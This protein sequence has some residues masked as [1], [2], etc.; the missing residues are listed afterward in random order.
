MLNVYERRLVLSY[1][2]NLASRLHHNRSEARALAECVA[3]RADHLTVADCDAR[4]IEE[5]L[6]ACSH[7]KLTAA[8]WQ[9]LR[10][11]LK[12]Q[13][14]ETKRVRADRTALRIRRLGRE[15]KLSRTDI[16][17]LD[18][19]L[20]Y[21]TQPAIESIVDAIV[22]GGDRRFVNVL[23]VGRR[24]LSDLLGLTYGSCFARFAIHA[25]LVRSGLLSIDNDGDIKPIDR[26]K[27]LVHTPGNTG[28]DAR[29]LLF[30]IG[31]PAEL[32][33]SDF[34]HVAQG[35]DHVESLLKGALQA[36]QA[37]GTGVNVLIY[38][39]PGTGKTEFC[40][41]LARR[42]KVKLYSV[43]EADDW[44]NEPN[45]CE[46]LQELRLAQRLLASGRD[47]ILLFDEMED[48][49]RDPAFMGM[50]QFGRF[51]RR[52]LPAEGSKVFM[53][54]LLEQNAVP[55]LWTSN[56]A[57]ETCPTVL[58]RMMFALE[59]RQPS[60]QVR[61]RIWARHL[62]SHG[63]E[64]SA[65]EAESL[66]RDYDVT[67]GVAAGVTAA[68]RLVEGGDIATVRCGVR[69]L[70]RLLSGETPPQG[71]PSKFDPALIRTDLDPAVL[72]ERLAALGARRVSLCLNGP[73]GTGKSAY[74]RYLAE[75]MGLQVVQ[76]R[77]SDL[78]SKWVGETE[79]R[80]AAAFAEARDAEQ[81]LVFDEAD[82]LLA[83][84]SLA[85]RSWE[86]S[87]VNEMLTWMESH[88]LPFAC[89]TNFSERLDPATLRRFDFKIT[90]DYLGSRQAMAAF[91]TFFG[92]AP[93]PGITGLAS[94]TP[95]DFAVVRRKAAILDK[96]GDPEAL[97]TMLREECEAKP[98]CPTAIGFR[99]SWSAGDLLGSVSRAG[100]G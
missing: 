48:L 14:A 17:I 52:R 36:L 63:I 53:N 92:L 97:A 69:S 11:I 18:F 31:P 1:L 73:P 2:S 100:Q 71:T 55:T 85:Q 54:R 67:P 41:T 10:D 91:R 93:P 9:Q 13:Q 37:R 38:G 50:P 15:M 98:N 95:G 25:P 8:R 83:D 27:R 34:E 75:R 26:L 33:W 64:A 45:R 5:R 57:R 72:A 19:L 56:A 80:I 78:M 6:Y 12:G 58:R 77:A 96:L 82:S 76:K 4:R 60:P 29:R 20:R 43:G 70:S 89:T 94:L 66:A 65:E 32:E 39:S 88:P 59:L 40:R 35:R 46:R 3:E 23:N 7:G 22:R 68:A 61:A 74:V 47:S 16:A 49:L 81:F 79:Q 87:Q 90:L 24:A 21:Q 99:R 84:R 86:L 30:D 62:A 28:A 42:L 51:G 44:G